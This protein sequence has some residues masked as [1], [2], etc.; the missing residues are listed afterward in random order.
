MHSFARLCSIYPHVSTSGICFVLNIL[1]SENYCQGLG[2][3]KW[4]SETF[5]ES[6]PYIQVRSD[7]KSAW[8]SETCCWV[9]SWNTCSYQ[10]WKLTSYALIGIRSRLPWQT[11]LGPCW[12]EYCLATLQPHCFA[13][14]QNYYQANQFRTP[15]GIYLESSVLPINMHAEAACLSHWSCSSYWP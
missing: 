10:Y 12:W 1:S 11:S 8:R 13:F 6:T 14:R 2:H 15:S 4:Y 7:S 5:C 3:L 9:S